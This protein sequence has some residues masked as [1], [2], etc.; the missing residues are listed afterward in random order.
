[1]PPL[2][3]GLYLTF[4][5]S[6]FL[7]ALAPGTD[8]IYV[9]TRSLSQGKQAGMLAGLGIAIALSLHVTAATL[10]LSQIFLASP[11]L[12][13][14]VRYLG[15][16]STPSWRSSSSPSCPSSPILRADSSPTSSSP[17]G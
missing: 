17:L 14:A 1:M 4:L 12:Y 11:G 7:L 3:P 10:G 8:N 5:G 15:I 16:A 6:V 2:D 13:L 9:V